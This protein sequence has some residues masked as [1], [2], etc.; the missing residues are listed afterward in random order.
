VS[1][2]TKLKKSVQSS[3]V[4]CG[5]PGYALLCIVAAGALAAGRTLQVVAGHTEKME[6]QAEK[7]DA[8]GK[9]MIRLESK[10]DGI[11]G[12]TAIIVPAQTAQVGQ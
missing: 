7:I 2:W 8:I 3:C 10:L 12:R 5:I 1:P 4:I 6:Q 9:G 11:T